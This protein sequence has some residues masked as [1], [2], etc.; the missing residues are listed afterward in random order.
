MN[1][2]YKEGFLGELKV[3]RE[4]IFDTADGKTILFIAELEPIF[5]VTIFN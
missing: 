1:F 3:L 4:L 5:V 2:L